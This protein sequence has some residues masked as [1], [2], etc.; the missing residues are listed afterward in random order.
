MAAAILALTIDVY[1]EGEI[2]EVLGETSVR[3]ATVVPLAE[4]NSLLTWL[5]SWFIITAQIPDSR[6]RDCSD[7]ASVAWTEVIKGC[8]SF[9]Y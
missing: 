9:G 6:V 7:S 4:A 5:R 8:A 1:Q 3:A 2:V